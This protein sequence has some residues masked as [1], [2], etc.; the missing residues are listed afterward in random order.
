[1]ILEEGTGS[2]EALV[3]RDKKTSLVADA[4]YAM[5]AVRYKDL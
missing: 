5:L 1:M 2:Y 4:R 3:F